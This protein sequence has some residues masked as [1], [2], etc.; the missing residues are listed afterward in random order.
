MHSRAR[1]R[2]CCLALAAAACG[3][4]TTAPADDPITAAGPP[5]TMVS[6]APL[7]CSPVQLENRSARSN[8]LNNADAFP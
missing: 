5:G 7:G 2:L 6:L 1:L 3:D 8:L 4:G